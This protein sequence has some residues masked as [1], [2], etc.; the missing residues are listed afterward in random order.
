MAPASPLR[1]FLEADHRRLETLLDESLCSD[2]TVDTARY[3]TFRAGLLRHIGIE[4]KVVFPAASRGLGGPLPFARELRI[5]HAA[6]TSLLVPTPDRALLNELRGLLETH[7]ALE[8]GNG[9]YARCDE[10]I[11]A[12]ERD[13]VLAAAERYPSVPVAKHFDGHGVHRTAASALAAA[14]N[15]RARREA[16]ST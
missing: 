14:T 12:G 9:A 3:A 11:A 10:L 7:D 1:L 16:S 15:I 13:A 2:G 8:E 6:I 5:Q 4:E